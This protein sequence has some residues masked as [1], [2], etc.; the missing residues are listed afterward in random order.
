[1]CKFPSDTSFD[2]ELNGVTIQVDGE[3]KIWF[4]LHPELLPHIGEEY[5]K[6]GILVVGESYYLPDEYAEYN[7][8]Q[9][10]E[11]ICEFARNWY[12][13]DVK[14]LQQDIKHL[15]RDVSIPWI[16]D[17]AN[18]MDMKNDVWQQAI[19]TFNCRGICE[20]QDGGRILKALKC[21]CNSKNFGKNWYSSAIS[22]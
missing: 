7:C 22:Y 13:T 8:K 19:D 14:G 18:F 21:C 4:D 1:M 3:D 11:M 5:K 10:N 6:S 2:D 9:Y 15:F 20:N 12:T 17:A 16:I